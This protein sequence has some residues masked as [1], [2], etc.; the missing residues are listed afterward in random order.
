MKKLVI[1]IVL[2]V[3]SINIPLSAAIYQCK[4]CSAG[5]YSSS[6]NSAS[7]ATCPSGYYCPGATDKIICPVGSKCPQIKRYPLNAPIYCRLGALLSSRQKEEC[8]KFV[9]YGGATSPTECSAGH[10]QDTT[11]QASC[12]SCSSGTYQDST[13][14][15]SCIKCSPGT[16]QDSSGQASCKNCSGSEY[17]PNS[18][19]SSCLSCKSSTE[20]CDYPYLDTEKDYSCGSYIACLVWCAGI[21]CHPCENRV[22]KTRAGH[23]N[24]TRTPNSARTACSVTRSACLDGS[25]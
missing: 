20:Y 21:S 11:G 4:P 10:Y 14:Q 12:K 18:G 6:V 7:C 24:V 2:F 16:Y 3:M 8:E 19:A 5:Q 1:F 17:Q 13:G 25:Q 23:I 22:W 9:F 15:T